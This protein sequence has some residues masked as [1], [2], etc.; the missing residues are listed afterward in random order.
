MVLQRAQHGGPRGLQ[1]QPST[2]DLDSS[3][4]PSFHCFCFL[5]FSD[6][7]EHKHWPEA[8]S[9]SPCCQDLYQTELNP[10]VVSGI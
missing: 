3:S 2:G 5:T 1:A 10:R 6:L 4:E 9:H 7:T 8:K